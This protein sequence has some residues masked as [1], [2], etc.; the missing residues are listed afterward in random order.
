MLDEARSKLVGLGSRD[1]AAGRDVARH[2]E[3]SAG[4]NR[5]VVLD[6]GGAVVGELDLA[7][8]R[9]LVR[10]LLGRHG[11]A[12]DG[13]FTACVYVKNGAVDES[14]G[15]FLF[16]SIVI[17]DGGASDLQ[18]A[19]RGLATFFNLELGLRKTVVVTVIGIRPEVIGAEAAGEREFAAVLDGDVARIGFHGAGDVDLAFSGDLVV[20]TGAGDRVRN[21]QG[22]VTF[23]LEIEGSL[24]AVRGTVHV[25]EVAH[26]GIVQLAVGV[27]LVAGINGVLR[28]RQIDRGVAGH[29]DGAAPGV[30]LVAR[31]DG[32]LEGDRAG[33]NFNGT[34]THFGGVVRELHPILECGC[35]AVRDVDGAGLVL[36]RSRGVAVKDILFLDTRSVGVVNRN[37]DLGGRFG[38]FFSHR[39]AGH[40]GDHRRD[41]SGHDR[42]RALGLHGGRNFIYNHQGAARLVENNLECRIHVNYSF[43]EEKTNAKV[44]LRKLRIAKFQGLVLAG[45]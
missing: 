45:G 13:K 10:V 18:V 39:R 5:D 25:D 37:R 27:G 23:G 4:F 41:G 29:A 19:E 26:V 6:R 12:V 15:G 1:D 40:A 31:D 11:D 35:F 30:S 28:N 43:W 3:F 9:E 22:C 2:G 21:R 38:N 8:G 7:V 32:V 42:L 34:T 16:A 44:L 36:V 14:A 20:G 33:L 17:L 24:L